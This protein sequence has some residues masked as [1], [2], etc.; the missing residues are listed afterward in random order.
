VARRRLRSGNV[1]SGP[2]GAKTALLALMAGRKAE[3]FGVILLD[4]RHRI[5]EMRELFQ[6]TI[7]GARTTRARSC[8]WRSRSALPPWSCFT[9]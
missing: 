4:K 9:T 1:L 8:A 6:G 5:I 7:D 3:C 2:Q